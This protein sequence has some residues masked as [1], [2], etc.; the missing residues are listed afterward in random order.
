ML[1]LDIY[2][3]ICY[4]VLNHQGGGKTV[5]WWSRSLTIRIKFSF[6]NNQLAN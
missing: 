3:L 2:S 1:I 6:V 5:F 4:Y